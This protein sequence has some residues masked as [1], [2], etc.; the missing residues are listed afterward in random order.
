[1]LVLFILLCFSLNCLNDSTDKALKNNVLF[2]SVCVNIVALFINF[3]L[4]IELNKGLYFKMEDKQRKIICCPCGSQFQMKEKNRHE[5]CKSHIDF[6]QS[7][8]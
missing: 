4:I 2:L 1:L 5:K 7:K 3:V 8:K 6:M